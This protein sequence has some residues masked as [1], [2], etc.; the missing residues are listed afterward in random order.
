MNNKEIEENFFEGERAIIYGKIGE[1][2]VKVEIP[3]IGDF[4]FKAYF[5]EGFSTNQFIRKPCQGISSFL[6]FLRLLK[7]INFFDHKELV[8]F[9]FHHKLSIFH[10]LNVFENVWLK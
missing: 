6:V 3:V 7:N 10:Y 5:P 1:Q 4:D 2:K 9:F 8:F